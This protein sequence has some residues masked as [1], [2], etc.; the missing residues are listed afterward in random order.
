MCWA[1]CFLILLLVQPGFY[2]DLMFC[3]KPTIEV[4]RYMILNR[5]YHLA[6]ASQLEYIRVVQFG[7]WEHYVK[8]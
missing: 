1:Y 7:Q 2:P 8:P 5:L 4:V 6:I 3:W